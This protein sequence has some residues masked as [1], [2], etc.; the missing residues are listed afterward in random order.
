MEIDYFLP[1]K[2]SS[3][4]YYYVDKTTG[5]S[6]WGSKKWGSKRLSKEWIR[7]NH[8]GKSI[9][10]Y[11]GNLLP[12]TC[13]LAYSPKYLN[14]PE[15]KIFLM[16]FEDLDEEDE[17]QQAE[18]CRRLNLF[19]K[20]ASLLNLRT[21]SICDESLEFLAKKAKILPQTI[22]DF[23]EQRERKQLGKRAILTPFSTIKRTDGSF[24]SERSIRELCGV[25]M[26][27]AEASKAMAEID[28]ELSCPITGT[29]FKDPFT[30]SSGHTFER[31]AIETHLQVSGKKCPKT[32]MKIT[33]RIIP[34]Y[35]LRNVLEK[36]V[37]KYEHQRGDIWKPI[38]KACLEFKNFSGILN[39]PEDVIVPE[40]DSDESESESESESDMEQQYLDMREQEREREIEENQT[41][42]T[43]DQIRAFMNDY[44]NLNG[45]DIPEFIAQSRDSSYAHAIRENSLRYNE[46]GRTAEEIRA[47]MINRGRGIEFIQDIPEFIAQSRNSSYRHTDIEVNRRYIE[48]QRRNG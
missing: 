9:Y 2:S 30:C 4:K 40:S 45:E 10:K 15:F 46:L 1:K 22:I 35:A 44:G 13:S 24:S 14:G 8:N 42:R 12:L 39:E 29:I 26:R 32:R 23:I 11:I 43:A 21:E 47:Y 16:S 7:L 31:S 3:C 18:A 19:K 34:N 41:G 38:V 36:F 6:Q 27:E 28:E 48:L 17:K 33:N 5:K 25:N 37:E 20:V